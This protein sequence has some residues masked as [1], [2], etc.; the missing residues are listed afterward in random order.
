MVQQAIENGGGHHRVAEDR[1]PLPDGAVRGDQHAAALV[2]AGDELEEQVR[3]IRVER[4]VAE[5]VDDQQLRLGEEGEPF[6][7]PGV[8]MRL[9][10]AG[11]QRRGRDEE[12]RVVLPD[13][14]A[15]ERDREMGLADPGWAE[16]Q[17]HIA[18]GDPAAGGEL[19]DLVRIE[20]RLRGEVEVGELA[21]AGKVRDLQ[22][23]LD[24]PLV[25]ARHLALAE[26]GDGLAKGEI[27]PRRLV[28]QRMPARW[29]G[30]TIRPCRPRPQRDRRRA[31]RRGGCAPGRH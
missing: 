20:A 6:L 31:G 25:L 12:H 29:L 3:R 10:E 26:E 24:S 15:A 16:E 21:G 9:G 13:R 14:F 27:L 19:A 4:Q 11:D 2:S 8:G 28:E 7:E 22:R 5:L 17:E 1:A 23:H 18:M 30:S